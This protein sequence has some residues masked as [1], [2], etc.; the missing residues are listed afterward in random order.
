[1]RRGL[2]ALCGFL[3]L[4]ACG[5]H[6][7][8]AYPAAAHAQFEASCPPSSKVCVCTWD[9]ITRAM[10]YDEYQAALE[11]YNTRGLMDPRITHARTVCLERGGG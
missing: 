6:A 5:A 3:F 4:A 10:T 11:R 9:E 7:P 2:P 8:N 1:M